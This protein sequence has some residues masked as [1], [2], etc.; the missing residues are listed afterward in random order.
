MKFYI[1]T[2]YN[3]AVK[4]AI[5]LKSSPLS[6][7]VSVYTQTLYG[8]ENLKTMDT[9]L[10]GFVIYVKTII[11]KLHNLNILGRIN[12]E[13]TTFPRLNKNNDQ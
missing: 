8:L 2:I 1:S 13:V 12:L 4:F 9:K 11:Y 10:S 5:F 7:A 6:I 3:F